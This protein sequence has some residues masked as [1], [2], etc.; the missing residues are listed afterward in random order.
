MRTIILLLL[1]SIYINVVGQIDH[2]QKTLDNVKDT[3]KLI[4]YKMKYPDE[5]RRKGIQ[6]TVEI[7]ATFDSELT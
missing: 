6:G 4:T 5:A 3:T 2:G 1:T 7:K